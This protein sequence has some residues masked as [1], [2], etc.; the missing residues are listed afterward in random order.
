MIALKLIKVLNEST[1]MLL[2]VG[3]DVAADDAKIRREMAVNCDNIKIDIRVIRWDDVD[4]VHL[5]Q[6]RDQWRALMNTVINLH[7]P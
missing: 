1:L 6:D 4:W 3:C 7:V 2:L 5:D